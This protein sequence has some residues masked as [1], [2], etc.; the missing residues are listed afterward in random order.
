MVCCLPLL[1]ALVARAYAMVFLHYAH[2]V[3]AP[4]VSPL[5]CYENRTINTVP[6][7]HYS[8]HCWFVCTAGVPNRCCQMKTARR[9]NTRKSACTFRGEQ[10]SKMM[11]RFNAPALQLVGCVPSLKMSAAWAHRTSQPGRDAPPTRAATSSYSCAHHLSCV[12]TDQS[13]SLPCPGTRPR[14]RPAS[15]RQGERGARSC[16]VRLLRAA[17]GVSCL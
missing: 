6:L 8:T 3:I 16:N 15:Q 7:L 9:T 5:Y 2:T 17:T 1:P 13:S 14:F 10:V 11:R 4:G 12:C